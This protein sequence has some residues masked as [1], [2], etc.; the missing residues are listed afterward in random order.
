MKKWQLDKAHQ[1]GELIAAVAV[2]AS[3]L[4]VA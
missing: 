3:L 1:I 2:V 4:L